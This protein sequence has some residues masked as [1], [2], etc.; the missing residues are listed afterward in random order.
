MRGPCLHSPLPGPV[1]A[2]QSKMQR[3]RL[4]GPFRPHRH[5]LWHA[6]TGPSLQQIQI[7]SRP[8]ITYVQCIT[9]QILPPHSCIMH[10]RSYKCR[11]VTQVRKFQSC[12]CKP[13]LRIRGRSIL[14]MASFL[15]RH[16]YGLIIL[17]AICNCQCMYSDSA[18]RSACI[19]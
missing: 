3:I 12:K 7:A 18:L 15:P 17:L 6:T 14:I 9:H 5:I 4:A 16:T 11:R 13:W 1:F 19:L 8:K 10:V 2:Q